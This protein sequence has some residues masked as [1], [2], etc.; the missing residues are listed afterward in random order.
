MRSRLIVSFLLVTSGI[1]IAQPA[2]PPEPAPPAEPAPVAVEPP[3]PPEPAP[4]VPPAPIAVPAPVAVKP[5]DKPAVT[6]KYDGGLKLGTADK[7]YELKL[8]FRNQFRFE[9]NRS[10]D[11]ESPTRQN[12]F[13]NRFFIPRS[14]LQAEG[15]LFGNDNRFKV[16]MNLGDQG[17]FGFLKDMFLEKRVPGTPAYVRAGQW[18][19]PFNRSELVSDFAAQ[20]NERSIQNDLAGG[21]RDLGVAIHNEYEKSPEGIE[22]AVGVFNGFSGGSDR[23]V[24]TT[25][26]TQNGAG[27]ITCANSRPATF[28]TDFG[29]AIVARVGYNSPKIKGYS[30]SDLEGGPLRY[31]VGGSYKI[32]LANF[33]KQDEE[34]VSD[35]L[36]HGL[37]VD[38]MIKAMGFSLH[39][40]VVMMKLKSAD[41]E[42]GAFAQAG[43]MVIPKHAEVAGRFALVTVG[44]RNRIEARGAFNW[45]WYGHTL[46]LASDAGFVQLTGRDPMT[47]A[48]DKPDL[49]IR[50]M[51]QLQI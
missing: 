36:S 3:P 28:P 15:H 20:L 31:A 25:T 29:P 49:Q 41:A 24:Q 6:A 39:A 38:T 30:E 19:R 33:A 7:M 47:M 13:T 8:S 23:P 12:Q 27:T 21:G 4:P 17:S 14:R 44:D 18:K 50:V 16:E 40:G 1:A 22:W 37:E 26:C 48:K 5:D 11:T 51:M 32:D 42:Y 2:P 45:F 46:K 10:F 43:M 35:N 9:S 34:S